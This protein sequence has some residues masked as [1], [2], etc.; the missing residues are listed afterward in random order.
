MPVQYKY[1]DAFIDDQR[2]L[3][4]YSFSLQSL[5]DRFQISD[6]T[7]RKALQRLKRQQSIA[8]VRNEFYA[9]VPPE[10]RA[11]GIIPP[12]FYIADLM[13]FLNRE[14]YIGLLNAAA[15]YGAAHQQPQ[16]FT[17]ITKGIPLRKIDNSTVKILFLIKKSWNEQDVIQKKTD[18]GYVNVSSPE[19]TALDLVNYYD[20]AGGFNRVATVLEELAEQMN[21]GKLVS[22]VKQYHQV[23]VAQRLGFL[24]ENV[25][26]KEELGNQLF[27]YLKT[28]DFFPTLLRPQKGKP[29]TM[30]TGNRWKVAANIEVEADI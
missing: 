17:I 12:S 26:Q 10:Y 13:K 9:I 25:L 15:F 8:M 24:L 6:D 11:K 1:L 22:S 5:R 7:L 30:K 16:D 29:K 23:V 27:D 14:Y 2:G 20:T 28:V 19:L 18:A 3:G 4:K 21:G